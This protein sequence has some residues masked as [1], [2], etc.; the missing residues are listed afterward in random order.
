MAVGE[1]TVASNRKAG[2][3]YHILRTVE[4]GLS[5]SGTEIKSIRDGHVSIREAYVRPVDGEMWLVG[6]HIAAYPPARVNHEPTRSRKLLLHTREI[7]ELERDAVTGGATII[8][9]RLYLK[10]GKAKLEIAL[11]R[12]KKK[13]DKREAIAKREA[14][15]SMQRAMRRSVR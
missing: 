14:E 7:R 1:K 3:D 6:A 2:F 11:A 12:G 10:G 9:T 15:R 5:L 4:A 13:Y 8:P